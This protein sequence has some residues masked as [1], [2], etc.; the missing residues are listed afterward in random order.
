MSF[1]DKSALRSLSLILLFPLFSPFPLVAQQCPRVEAIMVNACGQEEDNEFII[2][3]TGS[4]GFNTN[5]LQLSY[6]A[7]VNVTSA[8]NN[9]VNMNLNNLV[10]A[11]TPCG[12]VSGN[13][14]LIRGC[15]NLIPVGPGVQLAPNSIVV[16]QTSAGAVGLNSYDF[17]SLCGMGQCVYLM[18]SACNRTIPAFAQSGTSTRQIIFQ[19]AGST[20]GP[21]TIDY[22]VTNAELLNNG[23]YYL[24]VTNRYGNAGCT[25]PPTSPARPTPQLESV[26]STVISCGS[27]ILPPIFGTNLT[28]SAA[29]FTG[30]NRTGRRYLPGEV[31]TT[32]GTIYI[33]DFSG[34]CSDEES[35]FLTIRSG[36]PPTA[37]I[38]GGGTICPGQSISINFN[39]T[40]G[41]N[42]IVVYSVNGVLQ[43]PLGIPTDAATLNVAPADTT[44]YRLVSVASTTAGCVGTVSGEAVVNVRPQPEAVLSGGGTIC[45]GDSATL[46][47][48]LTGT[49]PFTLTL[50]EEGMNMAPVVINSGTYSLKVSPAVSS[51]Y[52]VAALTGAGSCPGKGSGSAAVTV[53]AKPNAEIEPGLGIACENEPFSLNVNLQGTPPF[54]F[55]YAID[56]VAQPPVSTNDVTHVLDLKPP[57]G[58][59]VISLVSVRS[60]TC[61][62]TTTGTFNLNVIATPKAELTGDTVTCPG[63]PVNLRVNFAGNTGSYTIAYTANGIDQ[64]ALTAT[65]GPYDFTARPTGNTVYVLKTFNANGCVGTVSGSVSVRIKTPPT[66][67]ISGG[68]TVCA[69]SN[70]TLIVR[71]TGEGPYTINYQAQAGANTTTFSPLTTTENP[72]HLVVTPVTGAIYRLTEVRSGSCVGTVSGQAIVLVSTPPT[73][74]ITGDQTFCD[75]AIANLPVRLT[76]TGPFTVTYTVNGVA[77]PP[78]T[79]SQSPYILSVNAGKTS[80]YTI[81]GIRTPGCTTGTFTGSA[82]LTVNEAPDVRNLRVNCL[83][84]NTEYQIELELTGTA[85]F[86]VA[87]GAGTI[88]GTRFL[89]NPVVRGQTYNFSFTDA[90]SCGAKT[91]TGT[92]NCTCSSNAGTMAQTLID[93][94]ATAPAIARAPTGV[95]RDA[96]DTLLYI[97]HTASGT[98]PGNIFGWSDQPR[99]TLQTGMVVDSIYY[100]SAVVGNFSGGQVAANDP[101]A[102]VS[103]GT[104]V[105]WN[106]PPTAALSDT[107]SICA[108]QTRQIP[109][110][111]TGKAPFNFSYTANNGLPI[112]ATALQNTFIINAT[113]LQTTT[114]RLVT[115]SNAACPTGAVSGQALVEV[116]EKPDTASVK[117]VCTADGERYVVTF[118]V[119]NVGNQPGVIEITGTTGGRYDAA[120][121]QFVS[122]TLPV[123]QPYSF[124]VRDTLYDCGEVAVSG[125]AACNCTVSA[126]TLNQ[127]AQTL[128]YGADITFSAATNSSTFA[129]DTLIYALVKG[130]NPAT[131]Q[132][133]ARAD[134]PF[135]AF[136]TNV[137]ADTIYRIVA[138]AGNKGAPAGFDPQDPCL[139]VS[140]GPT[141]RWRPV[142][143]VVFADTITACAGASL[144]VQLAFTGNGPFSF[145]LSDGSSTRNLTAPANSFTLPLGTVSG[146]KVYTITNLSG[147]GA[148]AGT[149]DGPLHV[150]ARQKPGIANRTAVCMP[151]NESY[152]VSFDI[153]NADTLAGAMS[154]TGSVAGT[155]DKNTRRF[156]S[157]PIPA[158]TPYQFS[159]T[160]LK[161]SCG[162]DTIQGV[163]PCK[164]ITAV[165]Q[166]DTAALTLCAG[167]AAVLPALSGTSL[168]IKDTLLYILSTSPGI[169]NT[170]TITA[171]SGTGTFAYDPQIISAD[172]RYYVTVM[173]GNRLPT[174]VDVQ[175]PCLSIVRG[176]SV[177]WRSAPSVSAMLTDS[178]CT[179]DSAI[180]IL[181]FTGQAPFGYTLEGNG[182][183]QSLTAATTT[184][185]I[186]LLPGASTR[187][188]ISGLTSAGGCAG[189]DTDSVSVVVVGRPVAR[190]TADTSV[191]PGESILLPVQLSGTG[192]YTLVY[193]T[194]GTP[195]PPVVVSQSPFTLSNSNVQQGV[196][197]RLVSV[198]NSVCTGTA[199]GAAFV[200]VNT[201]PVAELL[202]DT[203]IC[204]GDT[205]GLVLRL[206]GSTSFD[207]TVSGGL[208]PIVLTGVR[209]GD[210]VRVNPVV[211]TDYRL[212]N[213]TATGSNRCPVQVGDRVKVEVVDFTVD[214]VLS[215]YNGFGVSCPEEND[216]FVEARLKGNVISPRFQWNNGAT[217]RRIE[218]LTAGTYAVTISSGG[219][220]QIET[221]TLTAPPAFRATLS[222]LP[223]NCAGEATGT[224]RLTGIQGGV[225]PYRVEVDNRTIPVDSFPANLGLFAAGLYNLRIQDSKGCSS[226]ASAEVPSPPVL[227]VDAGADVVLP[228]G[229]RLTLTAE[230]SGLYDSVWWQPLAY[231][232]SGDSLSMVVRPEKT[233]VY[234][235]TVLNRSGCTATDEIRVSVD[236]QLR[237]YVPNAFA[238]DS[239]GNNSLLTISAGP[240]VSEVSLFRVYDRWGNL[241]YE[242]NNFSPGNPAFAW[243]GRTRNQKAQPGVY[244]YLLE[245]IYF[246]GSKEQL[247]GEVT[248]VR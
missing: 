151:D 3:H 75:T 219:C 245:V 21:Q 27:F 89:S 147:A 210:I 99:F 180:L 240:A 243:D 116:R 175:D 43:P 42:Y 59:H 182:A 189:S 218:N 9:D 153:T 26:P 10:S 157:N 130:T 63:Q 78:F 49:P 227:R 32:T 12:I 201:P 97:L 5:D 202:R 186:A 138:L 236:R 194:N 183:N 88:T 137:A 163:S 98:T 200:T 226:F 44:T 205:V 92:A 213:V 191:C 146:D 177:L 18:A 152:V 166:I 61:T 102:S 113:L 128:C 24:P 117:A 190:L 181:R 217:T 246:D 129:G 105:R 222:T 70:D 173:A 22:D 195:N 203:L 131:W 248:L 161:N 15:S 234:T 83:P 133:I 122:D 71:F 94:C 154:V 86:T 174:G 178:V 39:M 96:N 114:Y 110:E 241:M 231:R 167:Q 229:E 148:C 20:C 121:G 60:G 168:D 76:G 19:V 215:S 6:P 185:R 106:T 77:Q 50:A 158:F 165:G 90:A 16:F 172:K 192:P 170:T 82:T 17:S 74:E 29:Y 48:T 72:Y 73:A 199:N 188:V 81:T 31:V 4:T 2:I 228:F 134:K 67:A 132:I 91:V 57:V 14:S 40:G 159:V 87:N 30:P 123:S 54:E 187:Y 237:V 115:V 208:A 8:V 143:A 93:V 216:G 85:P 11:P 127:P 141:V 55:V 242:Q 108:G 69:G 125:R 225:G 160:D 13:T 164:C 112:T 107:F 118:Q 169:L 33:H 46:L 126:G 28:D 100:I 47:V 103:T 235:V 247:Q 207:L 162:E 64:P 65:Q 37:V 142:V 135:F 221:Y 206:S 223:P 101:C 179:G 176:P 52:T 41:A 36:T 224:I 144:S 95:V 145:T 140:L 1:L 68:K 7:S 149:V 155:F 51:S 212:T 156:T 239:D 136:P 214:G 56:N 120:T 232:L 197:Y 211:S 184:A 109:I 111:F 84:N 171:V 34:P 45:Q 35:F 80:T 193:S 104:P 58:N 150:V 38:S 230:V 79:T 244:V 53:V 62:G 198:S 119:K 25:V 209:N 233:T 124:I 204:I 66:A 23:G 196:T 238:P 139:S 220:Q